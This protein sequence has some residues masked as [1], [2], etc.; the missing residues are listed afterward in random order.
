MK[1]VEELITR[2]RF[3][4]AQ[5]NKRKKKQ[6][7]ARES[8]KD[9][10]EVYDNLSDSGKIELANDDSRFERTDADTADDN[11][12]DDDDDDDDNNN[13]AAK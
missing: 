4:A 5:N 13:E 3:V 12:D 6:S 1:E 10:N 2:N 8:E 9:N 7:N 11:D